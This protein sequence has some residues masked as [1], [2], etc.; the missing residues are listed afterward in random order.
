MI[1]LIHVLI[2]LVSL[3]VTAAVCF[4]PSL[5]LLRVSGLLIAATLG[6]GTYLVVSM[7]AALLS[8]CVSG[9]AF[10]AVSLAGAVYARHRLSR[11]LV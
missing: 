6:S 3:A 8:A 4:W 1:V 7:H 5:R 9:L 11:S 2:A 10:L